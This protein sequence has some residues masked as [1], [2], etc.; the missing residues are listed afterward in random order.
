MLSCELISDS[1]LP[2]DLLI[3][4]R[5]ENRR[6]HG[7]NMLL[8]DHILFL[9]VWVLI[10]EYLCLSRVR[11]RPVLLAGIVCSPIFA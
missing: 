2:K 10:D 1:L 5:A 6:K 11:A 8:N 4:R 9:V 3:G 7:R